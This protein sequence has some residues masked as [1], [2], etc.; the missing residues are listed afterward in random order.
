MNFLAYFALQAT[1][2]LLHTRNN[3]EDHEN[4]VRWIYFTI[5]LNMGE[6]RKYAR[7]VNPNH[8]SS[9][10]FVATYMHTCRYEQPY[11][12][13]LIFRTTNLYI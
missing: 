10:Y 7:N 2:V 13:P 11:N 8:K 12:L 5:V 1:L 6:S 9:Q 3:V 4:H